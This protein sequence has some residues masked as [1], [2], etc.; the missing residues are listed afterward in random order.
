MHQQWPP[1]WIDESGVEHT[2]EFESISTKGVA[3]I[4]CRL[5]ALDARIKLPE[6]FELEELTQERKAIRWVRA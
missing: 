5:K 4:D 3:L 2:F 1:R 6:R